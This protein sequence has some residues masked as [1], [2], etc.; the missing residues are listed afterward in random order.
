MVAARRQAGALA[1]TR[2]RHVWLPSSLNPRVA[3]GTRILGRRMRDEPAD[4]THGMIAVAKRLATARGR[5]G[6]CSGTREAAGR[7][8]K[9][10]R[11]NATIRLWQ[12]YGT[13]FDCHSD[14]RLR[15]ALRP[16][17]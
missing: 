4:S 16:G 14:D 8:A 13:A 6:N 15:R 2:A 1:T 11:L 9:L 12:C 17:N 3:A 5:R 7:D 10:G